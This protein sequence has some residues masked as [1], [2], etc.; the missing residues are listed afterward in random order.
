MAKYQLQAAIVDAVQWL[1]FE[2]GP[3]DLGVLLMKGGCDY[4]WIDTPEGGR[5][6]QSGDWLIR[7]EGDERYP[8]P[9]EIFEVLAQ[10]L[11]D[12]KAQPKPKG[13]KKK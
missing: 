10:P 6:V 3:H 8:I 11:D 13:S 4:G 9:P 12:E 1:G 5:P 2:H 7:G